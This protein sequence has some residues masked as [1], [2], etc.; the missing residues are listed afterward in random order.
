MEVGLLI[1]RARAA[2]ALMGGAGLVA[3]LV[4]GC[5]AIL[6]AM[7]GQAEVRGGGATLVFKKQ[8]LAAIGDDH[9]R[10][11]R[12]FHAAGRVA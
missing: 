12:N 9:V 11:V 6:F 10:V 3:P 1:A 5:S 2:D 4:V 7:R 8:Q